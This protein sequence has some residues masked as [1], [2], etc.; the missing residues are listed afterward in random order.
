M[1][2]GPCFLPKGAAGE[3]EGALMDFQGRIR[4]VYFLGRNASERRDEF[5]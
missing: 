5:S 3:L 1:E 2:V 4:N